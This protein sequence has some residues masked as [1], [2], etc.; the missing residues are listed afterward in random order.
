MSTAIL[1]TSAQ[2]RAAEQ[3]CFAAGVAED[4]LMEAA[5][6]ALYRVIRH[7]WRSG[8]TLVVFAGKG[9][10]AG[11]ALV[12]GR[13]EAE[14]T[15][16]RVELRRV[17]PVDAYRPLA[18]HQHRGCLSAGG[19]DCPLDAPLPARGPILL[20]DGLLGIGA[21]GSLQPEILEACRLMNR[22]R[23]EHRIPIAA[24]DTPTGL[25]ATTGIADPDAI[26]ADHTITFG[27]PKTGLV[28]DAAARHVGRLHVAPLPGLLSPVGGSQDFVITPEVARGWLPT[29]R[30][31]DLHKGAAGRVGIV[32]GGHGCVGAA[33][34]ASAAAMRSGAGLVALFIPKDLLAIAAASCVPEVMVRTFEEIPAWKADAWAVGPGL[35]DNISPELFEWMLSVP[36]PVLMDADALNWMAGSGKLDALLRSPAGPRLLTPHPGE[37]DRLLAGTLPD[38]RSKTRAEQAREFTSTHPVT[39]LLKGAR[40]VIAEHGHA[41]AYNTTGTPGMASG[42]MGDVLSGLCAGLLAQGCPA[43]QA[44]GL[45]SWL[46]GRAGELA[47]AADHSREA[48]C[49][50]DV[51]G[52]LGAAFTAAADDC[53]A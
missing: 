35:G 30:P 39:L 24:V 21:T 34:M 8:G 17:F 5:G 43:F 20:L 32:A 36:K 45:G 44:A 19:I 9:H 49:A 25:D 52:K 18:L 42:G 12:A 16:G 40:S 15:R 53:R 47:E 23:H 31:F 22:L 37:M 11:D 29:V 2:M 50:T 51:I 26:I 7:V 46:L 6:A 28:A 13:I 10:N 4:L 1:I 48:L 3:A 27:F 38:L 14:S 41:L 33:R